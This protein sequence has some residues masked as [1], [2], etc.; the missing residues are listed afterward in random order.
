MRKRTKYK[1]P[2]LDF[3]VIFFCLFTALFFA[4][5]FWQDLNTF[6]IRGD[7]KIVG[8]VSFKH[9]VAQRKFDDRVVWERIAQGTR[10]Y[11]GDTIRTADL[12]QAVIQL[13]DGTILEL[14]ENTMIQILYNE[15]GS[16]QISVDGD[17]QIDSS[18]GSGDVAL[19]LDDGSLVSVD[20]GTTLSAKSDA[21]NGIRNIE[22]TGGSAVVTTESGQS[23]TLFFGES[24]NIEN[25][26]ELQKNPLTVLYPPKNLK[27]L[28]VRG[29]SIPVKFSWNSSSDS[30]SEV[31]TLQLS[32]EKDFSAVYDEIEITDGSSAEINASGSLYWRIFTPSTKDSPASGKITVDSV[33]AVQGIFP[34]SG[35]EFRYRENLPK[36]NFR[37]SGNE[38]ADKYKLVVSATPD[39]NSVVAEAE[40]TGTFAAVDSLSEGSYWWRVTPYYSLNG[41]GYAGESKIYDFSI[42]KNSL[43]PPPKLNIPAD[44]SRIVYKSS[45][46][47]SFSW[48]TDVRDAS[49]R[50]I[51]ARDPSL[52]DIVFEESVNENRFVREVSPYIM[53]EGTYFWKVVRTPV[54]S[55]DR[56]IE[57]DV[58]SFSLVK[59]IPEANRLLYP[60]EDF[61]TEVSKISSSSFMWKLSDDYKESAAVSGNAG[62]AGAGSAGAGSAGAGSAGAG[63]SAISVLQVSKRS[64][65]SSIEI[66]KNVESASVTGLNLSDG[67]YWWRIGVRSAEGNIEGLTQARRFVVLPELAAPSIVSPSFAQELIVAGNSSVGI[68]W[69]DVPDADYYILKVLSKTSQD[70]NFTIVHQSSPR[71]TLSQVSLPAGSYDATVQAVAES[72]QNSVQRMSR[73]STVSFTVRA[74]SEIELT[75]PL[76]GE[77]IN[78]LSAL[79]APVSFSW[80]EKEDKAPSYRFIL[81]R[82]LSNGSRK[83]V[84]SVTTTKKSLSFERLAS[85]TY[86]WRVKASTSDGIPL[87][88]EER[89]LIID[90]VADLPPARL[91]SPEESAVLDDAYFRSNRKISFTWNAVPGATEY[92]FSLYKKDGANSLTPVFKKKNIKET[93]LVLKDLTVLD[94]GTFVWN[95]TASRHADDG[96]EEQRGKIASGTFKIDFLLPK[97]IETKKPK[98]LYGE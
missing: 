7:K 70:G 2:L 42:L 5:L 58:K 35:G 66:E 84:E 80:T 6:T 73:I 14:N 11:Y 69:K 52:G 89:R 57:S 16:L 13:D 1:S 79:T 51:I 50:L 74:P 46:P 53:G 31:V 8:T 90:T 23:A 68:R 81:V 19:K 65:F 22:V 39:M 21:K 61:V 48:K 96:F 88:S 9:R 94:I 77:H 38:Y 63:D 56:L 93:E 64:D 32:H 40:T 92:T 62:S 29:E 34:L 75:Y 43:I 72:S 49:Y 36:L 67:E 30:S 98:K 82:Q 87:D 4:Y 95:V 10:L 20:A 83:T 18:L 24:V 86:Y 71:A 55:E 41:I 33:S 54:D 47:L 85:G 37:W 26:A 60:P 45:I 15:S 97:L 78:G 12:A 28:D 25:G 91:I 44:N 17:I 27:L 3:T 59:Y 76:S